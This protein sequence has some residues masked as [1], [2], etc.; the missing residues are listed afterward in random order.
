MA[1]EQVAGMMVG[2]GSGGGGEGVG[3]LDRQ[4]TKGST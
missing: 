3:V 4:P 2:E 1:A